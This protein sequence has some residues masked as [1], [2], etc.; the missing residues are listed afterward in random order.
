[1][2]AAK[3]V[4][5]GKRVTLREVASRAGV[6]LK[7]ASN[8][9]NGNGRMSQETRNRVQGII[10]E[11]GYQINAAARNL[12][13]NKTGIITLAVPSLTPPYLAELANRVIDSAR[14]ED[15]AVYVSTYAEGSAKGAKD[16]LRSFNSTVS[17]GIILSMSEL[18]QFELEDLDVD[19]PLV[20]VGARTT[21]GVADHV[22]VDDAASG[23]LAADYLFDRGVRSLAV[24]GLHKAQ[25]RVELARAEEG[26][27]ELRMRGIL[28][29]LDRRSMVLDPHLLGVT[30]YGWSLGS[31]YLA[32]Q[33]IID[34]AVPFD[35]VIAL[36]DQ[37]AIGALSALTANGVAVPDQVQVI[38]FDNNEESAYLQTPLTTMDSCLGWISRTCVDRVLGRIGGGFD[39][40]QSL[41]VSSDV[42][43]RKTTRE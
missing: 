22:M 19:Y 29:A 30:G 6:S 34:S 24:I 31:G 37:L 28:R 36:N 26:N 38:G 23:E 21:Y 11:S 17:D 32:M 35:G 3:G 8:V 4:R 13:R 9:I 14:L 1:M 39:E 16:I 12:H 42:I 10:D 40:P 5:N 15:Y 20:C 18:E 2:A 41:L 25:D 33:D 27:A 7:T 43:A